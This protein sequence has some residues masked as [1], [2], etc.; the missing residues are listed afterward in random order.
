MK[1]S[2][3]NQSSRSKLT[4]VVPMHVSRIGNNT[5]R[6]RELREI[7]NERAQGNLFF[8]EEHQKILYNELRDYPVDVLHELVITF[9]LE[10]L[11]D[12]RS[13]EETR[14]EILSWVLMDQMTPNCN[15]VPFSFQ[16]CCSVLDVDHVE[17][18]DMI[19]DIYRSSAW[20]TWHL[21]DTRSFSVSTAKQRC[22]K[23][24]RIH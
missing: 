7:V 4:T 1:Q 12:H 22:S 3:R 5:Q 24:K 13:S 19:L 8:G 9:S 6:N 14:N 16:T 10:H 11:F 18:R 21:E 23:A 2:K 17:F 15:P 20:K